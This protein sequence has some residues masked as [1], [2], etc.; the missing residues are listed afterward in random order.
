MQFN[1]TSNSF[2]QDELKKTL[3]K[4]IYIPFNSGRGTGIVNQDERIQGNIYD[5]PSN[6]TSLLA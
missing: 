2:K 1:L 6:K 5:I 4:D 3:P